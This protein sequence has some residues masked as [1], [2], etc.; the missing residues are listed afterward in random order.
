MP[1]GSRSL[2]VGGGIVSSPPFTLGAIPMVTNVAPDTVG[3]SIMS[4]TGL[5]I[6][7]GT[8]PTDAA[9]SVALPIL[10]GQGPWYP[11]GPSTDQLLIGRNV[12]LV[13]GSGRQQI[14]IGTFAMDMDTSGSAANNV[15]NICIGIN[16]NVDDAGLLGLLNNVM[17]GITLS[18]TDQGSNNV[19]IGQSH[20]TTL[21]SA[22]CVVIGNSSTLNGVSPSALVAIGNSVVVASRCVAI[23]DRATASGADSLAIGPESPQATGT[24][25]IAIGRA[26]RARA[27]N[28]ICIGTLANNANAGDTDSVAIGRNASSFAANQ[29]IFGGIGARILTVVIGE[30]NEPNVSPTLT[31]IVIR[32]SNVPTGAAPNNIAGATITIATGEGTGNAIGGAF[33]VSVPLPGASSSTQ[34]TP[35]VG[36]EVRPTITAT[37]TFLMI[38]DV[39]NGTLERVSVGAAGSGGGAFKLLRIPN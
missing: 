39:D 28:G 1:S 29:L 18:I 10:A 5:R 25:S 37:E 23:G 12:N 16:H 24:Q 26:T 17:L 33:I 2:I 30:G 7:V 32:T 15:N 14:I 34:Q 31:G 13:A 36:L 35:T 20:S 19:L 11:G 4:Q 22:N 9:T 38:R 27:L 6:V 8:D 21:Q 3:D